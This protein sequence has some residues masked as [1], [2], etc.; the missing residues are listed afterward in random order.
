MAHK[1]VF[2]RFCCPPIFFIILLS[3]KLKSLGNI[4]NQIKPENDFEKK[5]MFLTPKTIELKS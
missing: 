4:K 3:A 2:K 5:I 1:I